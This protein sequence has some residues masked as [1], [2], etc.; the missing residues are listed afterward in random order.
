MMNRLLNGLWICSLLVSLA[1]A[2]G[3]DGT[4]KAIDGGAGLAGG[5]EMD[6]TAMPDGNQPDLVEP[7]Q[8]DLAP[9]SDLTVADAGKPDLAIVPDLS[10]P[11][12]MVENDMNVPPMPD[13]AVNMSAHLRVVNASPTM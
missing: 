9:T 3:C 2:A 6:M 4:A 7:I 13:M 5:G 8:P 10:G 1:C 12:L 11:D